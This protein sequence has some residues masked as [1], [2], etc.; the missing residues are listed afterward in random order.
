METLEDDSI[1]IIIIFH[2]YLSASLIKHLQHQNDWW[3]IFT[4]G[5]KEGARTTQ[6]LWVLAIKSI[7]H[8]RL[9]LNM[10]RKCGWRWRQP[11]AAVSF[12]QRPSHWG[13]KGDTVS[14]SA[15]VHSLFHSRKFER[16][17]LKSPHRCGDSDRPPP[18]LPSFFSDEDIFKV[19]LPET[20]A[21]SNMQNDLDEFFCHSLSG[22]TQIQAGGDFLT[23]F[24]SCW[25]PS[26]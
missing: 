24:N 26:Y 20:N 8:M 12:G 10:E 5:E 7:D 13:H 14:P 1:I 15:S 2:Y 18:R 6:Q 17:L 11:P 21:S 9:D 19:G 23:P 4:M 22:Q 3:W 25:W 16:Q